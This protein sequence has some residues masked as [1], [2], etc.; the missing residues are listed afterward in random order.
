[1]NKRQRCSYEEEAKVVLWGRGNGALVKKDT[2]ALVKKRQ[3]C[4]CEVEAG[5]LL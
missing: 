1:M 4:S 3:R 2:G 5:V